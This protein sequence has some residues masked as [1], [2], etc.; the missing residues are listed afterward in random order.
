MWQAYTAA[1]SQGE[2][3]EKVFRF[4]HPNGAGYAKWAAALRPIL[5]TLDYLETKP[6]DFTPEAGFESLFNGHD[7]TGWEPM[8]GPGRNK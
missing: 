6:D 2:T 7:L 1:V 3:F 4:L 8:R 5:A